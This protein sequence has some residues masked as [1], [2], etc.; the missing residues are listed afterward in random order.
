[1]NIITLNSLLGHSIT[2]PG[3]TSIYFQTNS[4]NA[5][6]YGMRNAIS[7][8]LSR[9]ALGTMRLIARKMLYVR[10]VSQCLQSLHVDLHINW[11]QPD[12]KRLTSPIILTVSVISV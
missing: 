1:M 9:L 12:R 6:V 7:L 4:E 3:Q 8:L 2:Q 11:C 10:C 5:C